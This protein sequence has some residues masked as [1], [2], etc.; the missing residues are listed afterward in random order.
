MNMKKAYAV[1]FGS[2]LLVACGDDNST[3]A[4]GSLNANDFG[5]GYTYA[6]PI[7]YDEA[8]GRVYQGTYA[9]NYHPDTKTFAWEE[10]PE[11][12]DPSSYKIVGDSLWMGPVTKQE[13]ENEDQQSFYGTYFNYETL[14]LSNNHDGIYG[15]WK[16]TGCRRN[17]GSTE[18]KCRK[19]IGG[20]SG[21]ARTLNI[22]KDTIYNTTTVDLDNLEQNEIKPASIIRNNLGF[23]IAEAMLSYLLIEKIVTKD[24]MQ[25]L[26]Q[27][28]SIGN[29]KFEEEFHFKFDKTG[30]NYIT[31]LSSNGK[32]CTKTERA[33]YIAEKQC[34]E[35]SAEFLLSARDKSEDEL[36]Y[37]EG[38]VEG[39][40]IDNN[41]EFN[42]CSKNLP[43]E[44]TKQ[45]LNQYT[46]KYE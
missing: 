37:K 44:E 5:E 17:L 9:C 4:T 38:P 39:F 12:L 46:T 11:S 8:T 25:Q 36:Y 18:I 45:L 34:K 15:E 41:D 35:E 20:L 13:A 14:A 23:D 27:S 24:P 6:I 42:E 22:T 7:K 43:T 32:T 3:S 31:T 16:V 10:Y 2:F 29:Q 19:Y 33:G 30:M 28:F 21:I 26:K 40:G 1:L